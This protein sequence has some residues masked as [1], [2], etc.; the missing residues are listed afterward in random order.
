[1]QGQSTHGGRRHAEF[2][3]K[4]STSP[5]SSIA[6]RTPQDRGSPPSFN[7]DYY[8]N[9]GSLGSGEGKVKAVRQAQQWSPRGE[10]WSGATVTEV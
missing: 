2:S 10:V 9:F 8:R 4:M 6:P 7:L 1:M 5:A 3:A